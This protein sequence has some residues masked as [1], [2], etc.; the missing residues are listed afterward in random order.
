MYN[1]THSHLEL[2]SN[3]VNPG[4]AEVSD[5][6]NDTSPNF[7]HLRDAKYYVL[8]DNNPIPVNTGVFV[9]ISLESIHGFSFGKLGPA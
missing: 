5:I 2:S 8:G 3:K 4:S 1:I 7:I 6:I 9:R